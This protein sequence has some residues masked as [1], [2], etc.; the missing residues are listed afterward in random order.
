MV[1]VIIEIP[2]NSHVKYEHDKQ[3]NFMRCDRILNTSMNYP[4]NYGYIPNTLACD[5]D[6]LDV[7]LV[8][9]YSL[10]PGTII[11]TRIIGVLLMKDEDG[12][13]EKII[14]I[15]SEKVDENYNDIHCLNNLPLMILNKIKHFFTHYKDNDSNKWSEV[16]GFESAEYAMNLIQKYR[17][18]YN[19]SKL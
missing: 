13:D 1:D 14:A 6:P 10:Y 7:L 2:Y 16:E 15:P 19:I 4:G 11:E 18:S 5:G 8:T 12:I 3:T 17:E 9:D